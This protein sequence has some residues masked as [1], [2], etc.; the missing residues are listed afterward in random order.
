MALN[1]FSKH[2]T[3]YETW[4]TV[5]IDPRLKQAV[6][7]SGVTTLITCLALLGLPYLMQV[8]ASRFFLLFQAP[9]QGLLF[10]CWEYQRWLVILNLATLGTYATLWFVTQQMQASQLVWLRV[11]Y[12]EAIIGAINGFILL[13]CSAVIVVNVIAWIVIIIAILMFLSGWASSS[14]RD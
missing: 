14:G 13:L 5:D 10:L 9:L 4:G 2:M 8:S 3:P 11:A 6:T 1:D 12:A 7:W